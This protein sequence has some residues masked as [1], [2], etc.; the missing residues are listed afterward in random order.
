MNFL[1]AILFSS[2]LLPLAALAANPLL[3]GDTL[4]QA[5]LTSASDDIPSGWCGRAMLSLLNQ[6]GVGRGLKPGNGQEWEKIL[7]DAGWKSV[8]VSSPWRAPLGSVLVYLGDR[9][10]GKPPRGTPGGY[11]GHVEMVALS[12]IGGRMFVADSPRMVPGGSVPDNFTGRAWVPPGTLMPAPAPMANQIDTIMQQ[13]LQMALEH[14]SASGAQHAS[15]G[16][17]PQL[18]EG[19]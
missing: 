15:L 6:S 5:T 8:K 3:R 9:L 1:R 10:L 17:G 16:S 4:R 14:F 2:L 12:P 18:V 7:A 11:F 13:R 19:R